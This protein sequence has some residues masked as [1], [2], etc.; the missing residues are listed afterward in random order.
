[1]NKMTST[2]KETFKKIVNVLPID[3]Q[4][5]FMALVANSLGSRGTIHAKNLG[6]DMETIRQGRH[7]LNAGIREDNSVIQRK[8]LERHYRIYKNEDPPKELA[9]NFTRV[10][11]REKN[12]FPKLKAAG[13]NFR[14]S[15]IIG[16]N[17]SEADL[18]G[19]DLWNVNWNNSFLAKATLSSVKAR[20]SKF[21]H[22]IFRNAYLDGADLTGSWFTGSD[23]T[24]CDLRG[25]NLSSTSLWDACLRN[26]KI[27]ENTIFAG[28]RI[29]K[30]TYELSGWSPSNLKKY[31]QRGLVIKDLQCF[32]DTVWQELFDISNMSIAHIY[33]KRLESDD[34]KLLALAFSGLCAVLAS[35]DRPITLQH[36]LHGEED[37]H[38]EKK[39]GY[40]FLLQSKS[41]TGLD[42]ILK[43]FNQDE[44]SFITRLRKMLPTDPAVLTEGALQMIAEHMSPQN[45]KVHLWKMRDGIL[46][47]IVRP[48]TRLRNFLIDAFDEIEIVTFIQDLEGGKDV[49]QHISSIKGAISHTHLVNEIISA[50]QRR[51]KINA[52]FFQAL[53]RERDERSNEVNEIESLFRIKQAQE[54]N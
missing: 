15:T 23:M 11:S 43:L 8:A 6:W 14:Q 19:A 50:M 13:G 54:K 39:V 36:Y 35:T 48:E 34:R 22:C 10:I 42:L 53:R 31:Y 27:D 32:P 40:V 7:E 26:A 4:P 16:A 41:L 52:D 45:V 51:G 5:L 37:S 33:I 38:G 49:K 18:T 12:N 17:L 20:Y 1:M 44:E 24:G 9:L 30:E 3:H 47:R 28:A 29:T 25:T 21:E 2:L 46:D